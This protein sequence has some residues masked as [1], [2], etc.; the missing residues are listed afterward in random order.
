MKRLIFYILLSLSVVC[1]AQ[2][3]KVTSF[4]IQPDDLTARHQPR[5]DT[6]GQLG[7][8]LKICVLDKITKVE[9]TVL[10]DIVDNG[11]EKWVYVTDRTKKIRLHFENHFPL[12]IV[13]DDYNYASAQE[14]TV[15]EVLLEEETGA[16]AP[17]TATNPAP[18]TVS[19][20]APV[21]ASPS[22]AEILEEGKKAYNSKNY[23]KALELFRKIDGD[24]EA[25]YYIGVMYAIGYGVT[26]D[27]QEALKWY[28]KAA[29]QGFAEAM[30]NL[31]VTYQNGDGVAKDYKEA[32]K[33]Y[34]KAAEQGNARAPY[35]LG[36]MYYYGL[37]VTQDY[38]EAVKWYRKAAELGNA[39]AQ[40]NLGIMYENGYGVTKDQQEAVKWYRKAAEQG[41]E[42][43]KDALKRLGY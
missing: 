34:R 4:K 18:S 36:V 33:W 23:A 25:Q 15:Y 24:K 19:T 13:F 10:G 22:T 7:A 42:N 6:D 1:T 14:K 39:S 3:L 35:N 21:A 11:V 32:V 31:G 8:L 43:A 16:S 28:R 26:K 12:M 41:N 38:Q 20:P 37:G 29:E 9:G 40:Y 2:K 5:V 30:C 27:Y 17:A